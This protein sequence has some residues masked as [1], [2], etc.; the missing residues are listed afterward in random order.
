MRDARTR[1]FEDGKIVANRQALWASIRS[2][3]VGALVGF[4]VALALLVVAKIFPS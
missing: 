4:A 3:V 1:A 2:F